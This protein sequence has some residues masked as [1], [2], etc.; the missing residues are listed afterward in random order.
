MKNAFALYVFL[1][2]CGYT[3]SQ[4][5]S[6]QREL[7][8]LQSGPMVGYSDY[9]E[10]ALW[11]QTKGSHSVKFRYY[12]SENIKEAHWTKSVI[13]S[14]TNAF[15]AKLIADS[16]EAG[17]HYNYEVYLDGKKI[18]LNRTLTFQTQT[19]WQWRTD[20]PNFKFATGSCVYVNDSLSDRPGKPYGGGYEIFESIANENPD[21]MVWTGDNT[22][23][24]EVDWNTKSGM[25]YRNTHTRSLPEMQELLGKTHNYAIWDDHD[26]G[27][28]N[29]DRSFWNKELSKEVFSNF[30]A[31]PSYG[32]EGVP[33]ITTYFQW[34]DCDFFLLDNRYNRSVNDRKTGERTIL[35]KEQLSWLKDALVASQAP[36]KFVV[37]GG[38][39]LTN[40]ECYETYTNYG[41]ERERQEIIDYIYAEKVNGVVFLNGDRHHTE[42]S[43]LVSE[44]NPTIYDLTVSPLTSGSHASNEEKN[45]F[46]IEGTL[47]GERNYAIIE[48]TGKRK[49]R[50]LKITVKGSDGKNLW[51]KVIK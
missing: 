39:F 48:V 36:Y 12:K 3:N 13:T 32:I 24:R 37:L 2:F 5:Q 8:L 44:N 41:F 1:V 22:Y 15:I 50:Q 40:C 31:N 43:K 16:L 49:E 46:R 27:P 18:E 25:Y 6:F 42:F 29:S 26:F 10:V 38:Q 35:G 9:K 14:Q 23:Y 19:L 7:Q 45:D 28:N 21:F 30:W 47:V 4:N 20:P 33:G 17:K 51:S 11:V 34:S